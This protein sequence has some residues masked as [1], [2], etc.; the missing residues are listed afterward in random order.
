MGVPVVIDG[1]NLLYARGDAPSAASRAGLV[2]DL[3]RWAEAR[4]RRAV[5]V[6]DAWAR[7][8][9]LELEETRGPLTVYFTRYG[10]RADQ[11][12]VRWVTAHPEAV[13]VTSD[14]AVQQGARRRGAAVLDASAFAARLQAALEPSGAD[15]AEEDAPEAGRRAPVRGRQARWL[16]GL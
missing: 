4:Q 16:R 3:I 10:E 7:G 15:E 8:E 1:Y 6:F 14:R 12:I 9:R 13:V 11:H 5:V 2:R